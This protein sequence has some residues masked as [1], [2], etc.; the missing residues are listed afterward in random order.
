[1][2]RPPIF[3]FVSSVLHWNNHMFCCNIF[4]RLPSVSSPF[5]ASVDSLSSFT[6]N[7]S[8]FLMWMISYW[9]LDTLSDILWG[10]GSYLNILLAGLLVQH[11]EKGGSA[12]LF[13]N[14]GGVLFPHL[15]SVETHLLLLDGSGSS[16]SPLGWCSLAA[17]GRGA[18]LL[19][20]C[21]F[22][23]TVRGRSVCTTGQW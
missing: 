10:S 13:P 7:F 2:L 12:L 4:I 19:L 23:D 21:G 3:S 17:T 18:T 9:I 6:L 1:M 22:H 15:V 20:P 14:E 16:G 5:L 8:W 11:W